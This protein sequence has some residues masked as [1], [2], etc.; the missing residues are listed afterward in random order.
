M[1]DATWIDGLRGKRHT[2]LSLDQ[3]QAVQKMVVDGDLMH[4]DGGF[5]TALASIADTGKADFCGLT[6]ERHRN[7][8]F[9]V[10]DGGDYYLTDNAL[11]A[12]IACLDHASGKTV[13]REPDPI[14]YDEALG[15]KIDRETQLYRQMRDAGR[16]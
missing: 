1:N 11:D 14:T 5:M 4:I 10:H 6:V 13:L 7:S 3:A 12:L 15:A 8:E 2:D 16:L 9:L